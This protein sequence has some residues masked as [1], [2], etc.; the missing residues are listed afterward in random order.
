MKN[1]TKATTKTLHSD[2]TGIGEAIHQIAFDSD[3]SV[4]HTLSDE[5]KSVVDRLTEKIGIDLV[6]KTSD[7][8]KLKLRAM[9]TDHI[10]NTI[11]FV[12]L[13]QEEYNKFKLGH[14]EINGRTANEWAAHLLRELAR[15]EKRTAR[16]KGSGMYVR[17]Q[18]KASDLV[19][20]DTFWD[21]DE[22]MMC[23]NGFAWEN[24]DDLEGYVPRK[25]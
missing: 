25:K 12:G 21:A 10:K 9:T 8:R 11:V 22:G 20:G 13:R 24:V 2:Y 7:G 14:Y 18:F 6:W 4:Y 15:R 17:Q 16:F 23:W 3:Y 5:Q 19:K 1:K